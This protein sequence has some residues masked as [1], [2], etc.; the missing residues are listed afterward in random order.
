MEAL[1]VSDLE[2]DDFEIITSDDATIVS[3]QVPK[4]EQDEELETEEEID[5]KSSDE[6][7]NKSPENEGSEQN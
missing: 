4:E 3:V 2:F 7:E 6:E 5:E 1:H